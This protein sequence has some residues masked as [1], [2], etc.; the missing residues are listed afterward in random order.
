MDCFVCWLL[1]HKTNINHMNAACQMAVTE[2]EFCCTV[3]AAS[4]NLTNSQL[5]RHTFGK[6]LLG[7]TVLVPGVIPNEAISHI[8]CL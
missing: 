8:S 3:K 4:Q 7:R 2:I 1:L 6:F 5:E